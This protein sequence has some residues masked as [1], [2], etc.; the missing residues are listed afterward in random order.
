MQITNLFGIWK[1]PNQ[2]C[3]VIYKQGNAQA[4]ESSQAAAARNLSAT[5]KERN[6]EEL[7]A[8]GWLEKQGDGRL[9]LGPRTFMELRTYIQSLDVPTCNA[10]KEPAVKVSLKNNFLFRNSLLRIESGH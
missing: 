6:I 5:D 4:A 8:D 2:P 9:A 7:V 10:C 1:R 3:N